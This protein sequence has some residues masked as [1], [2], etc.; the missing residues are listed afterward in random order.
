MS[1]LKKLASQTAVYGISSIVGRVLT[2]LLM[3]IY[4]GA[5]AA[6]EYGVVTGLYAY[7][8]FLNVVFTYGME[9]TFFRFANRPDI[10]RRERHAEQLGRQCAQY[11]GQDRPQQQTLPFGDPKEARQTSKR[12]A[13]PLCKRF[14]AAGL[15]P[16]N[17]N[18]DYRGSICGFIA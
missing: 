5:F 14:H 17:S 9:S 3:P 8:S 7:V 18:L 4:T 1:V 16:R 15:R 11:A 13:R 10:D 2:Y 6:A 12:G